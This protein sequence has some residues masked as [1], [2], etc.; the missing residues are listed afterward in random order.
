MEDS[1]KLA[2]GD[3][4]RVPCNEHPYP[5]FVTSFGYAN[6][7]NLPIAKGD[8]IAAELRI[9]LNAVSDLDRI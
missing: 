8:K 5:I 7:G 6:L 3:V 9:T 2:R 1:K 4:G